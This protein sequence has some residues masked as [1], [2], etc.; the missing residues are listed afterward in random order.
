MPSQTLL[1]PYLLQTFFDG[2]WN[3][4]ILFGSQL[5]YH[6][7]NFTSELEAKLHGVHRISVLRAEYPEVT[8]EGGAEPPLAPKTK[9]GLK[10]RTQA[11][12]SPKGKKHDQDPTS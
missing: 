5:V 12:L 6:A 4:K 1:K 3:C 9:Y 8:G 2:Q 7:R 10:R 11:A